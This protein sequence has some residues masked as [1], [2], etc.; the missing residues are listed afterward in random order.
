MTTVRRPDVRQEDDAVPWR[1]ISLVAA[2]VIAVAAF[3]I[4]W[5]WLILESRSAALRP[6]GAY[7]ERDIKA[8]APVSGVQQELFGGEGPGEALNRR[9]RSALERFEWVDRERG[10][11]RVPI[12][13]AM[14]RVAEEAAP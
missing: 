2:G 13:E 14:R 3:L 10:L 7:P 8:I 11:V 4:V 6:S 5:A 1:F 12:E 9:R